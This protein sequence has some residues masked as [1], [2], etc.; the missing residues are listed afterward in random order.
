MWCYLGSAGAAVFARAFPERVSAEG[1]KTSE[2]QPEGL[3]GDDCGGGPED[4]FDKI[5][6]IS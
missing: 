6:V 3:P 4:A 2:N 1:L 5:G